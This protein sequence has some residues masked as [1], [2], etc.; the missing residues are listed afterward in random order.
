MLHLCTNGAGYEEFKIRGNGRN[1]SIKHHRL[2]CYAW[3]MIDSP[4][5]SKDDREVHHKTNISWLNT[6]DNLIALYPEEHRA[7]DKRRAKIPSTSDVNK[8][9]KVPDKLK[10]ECESVYE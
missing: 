7:V 1:S 2:L 6:Q 8:P 10:Q 4:Y 9:V 5:I 3:D